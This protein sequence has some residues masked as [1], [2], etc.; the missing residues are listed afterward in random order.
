VGAEAVDIGG[1]PQQGPWEVGWQW[2]WWWWRE[3]LYL[4]PDEPPCDDRL[5]CLSP[6]LES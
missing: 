6:G 1:W 2:R 3:H 4:Q 5:F